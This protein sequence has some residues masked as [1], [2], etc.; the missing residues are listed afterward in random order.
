MS[1][2]Q[3]SLIAACLFVLAS[4]ISSCVAKK[5]CNCPGVQNVIENQDETKLS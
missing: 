4:G 3:K 1:K 5:K 2:S